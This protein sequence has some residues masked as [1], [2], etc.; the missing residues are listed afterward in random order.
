MCTSILW[1]GPGKLLPT[2]ALPAHTHGN[3]VP[4]RQ[5]WIVSLFI[6]FI[7]DEGWTCY[8][9]LIYVSIMSGIEPLFFMCVGH[10]SFSWARCD[11]VIILVSFRPGEF[12]QVFLL[13]CL[14]LSLGL[15]IF[16]VW[17]CWFTDWPPD[18]ERRE[19]RQKE[20]GHCRWIGDRFDKQG[21]ST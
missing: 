10:S 1:L 4:V 21:T 9:I 6:A 12:A 11:Y 13:R 18:T 16:P 20:A 3:E 5:Q 17:L 8:F 14:G 15:G 7:I 2:K 19:R